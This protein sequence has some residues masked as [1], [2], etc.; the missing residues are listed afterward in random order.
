MTVPLSASRWDGHGVGLTSIST[1]LPRW[2]IIF[3]GGASGIWR[4]AA[5]L[6]AVQAAMQGLSPA[7]L[8]I[9]IMRFIP[10]TL[11]TF[12]RLAQGRRYPYGSGG[13]TASFALS[14]R[15]T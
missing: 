2:S 9:P 14:T 6:R 13:A 4:C 3:V 5:G 12:S 15:I 11:S 7:S 10:Q 1:C 8:Q